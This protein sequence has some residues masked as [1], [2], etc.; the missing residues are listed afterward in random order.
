MSLDPVWR[1]GSGTERAGH[2]SL[3]GRRGGVA[4]FAGRRVHLYH[5]PGEEV[6]IEGQVL[7][8]ETRLHKDDLK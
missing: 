8:N 5:R 4:T 3:H 2:G 6:R 1:E 7:M